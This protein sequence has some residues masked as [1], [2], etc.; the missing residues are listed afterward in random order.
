MRRPLAR[1]TFRVFMSPLA[2]ASPTIPLQCPIAHVSTALLRSFRSVRLTLHRS[3]HERLVRGW[4]RGSERLPP[5]Y[6]L[7]TS[8]TI[9]WVLRRPDGTAAARFSAWGASKKSVEHAA[10]LDHIKRS[11][12]KDRSQVL[13]R[14]SGRG[15]AQRRS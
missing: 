6:L 7:D 1:P 5:G 15:H 4:E 11:G 9:I 13:S 14:R 2:I 3:Y 10:R 12:V 8:D